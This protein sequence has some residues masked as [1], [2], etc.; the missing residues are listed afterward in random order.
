MNYILCLEIEISASAFVPGPKLSDAAGSGGSPEEGSRTQSPALIDGRA[1]GR[2]KE[3]KGAGKPGRPGQ[4]TLRSRGACPTN[5]PVCFHSFAGNICRAGPA[6]PAEPESE[7]RA[8]IPAAHCSPALPD[9]QTEKT[10]NTL[11]KQPRPLHARFSR[12][13]G[14]GCQG[15][16]PVY[17]RAREML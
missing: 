15:T 6:L 16:R 4:L 1:A 11:S 10:H 2:T 3:W 9:T 12:S 7:W 13:P 5:R 8:K 14:A 17:L